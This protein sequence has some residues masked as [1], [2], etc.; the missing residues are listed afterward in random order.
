MLWYRNQ[1]RIHLAPDLVDLV[2]HDAVRRVSH[3]DPRVALRVVVSSIQ[4]SAWEVARPVVPLLMVIVHT[5]V[6][7]TA[8]HSVNTAC[9]P[10]IGQTG[11][12]YRMIRTH[13]VSGVYQAAGVRN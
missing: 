1:N 9:D 10:V 6:P 3:L 4:Y 8:R 7:V 5:P 11:D 2:A 13:P 12:L